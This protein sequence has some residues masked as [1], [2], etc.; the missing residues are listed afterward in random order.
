MGAGV[1]RGGEAAAAAAARGRWDLKEERGFSRPS[2][3]FR[4][5]LQESATAESRFV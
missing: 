5:K 1:R 4:L 3:F 2:P